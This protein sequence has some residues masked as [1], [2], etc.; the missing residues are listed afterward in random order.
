M[1]LSRLTDYAVLLLWRMSQ[2]AR[3]HESSREGFRILS[4]TT[5]AEETIVPLPT[6]AKV[7]KSLCKAGLLH[8]ARGATG[9]YSLAKPA[10]EISVADI[11]R[12]IEGPV[13][14]AAC[15]EDEGC[16]HSGLCGMSGNWDVVNEAVLNALNSI[17]LMQMTPRPVSFL[18]PPQ[19]QQR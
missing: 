18:E 12:A 9:G 5:L 15:V 7:L 13:A 2:G 3:S 16:E 6:V 14:L 10:A 11:I 19:R 8:S 1:K 4:A 17:N